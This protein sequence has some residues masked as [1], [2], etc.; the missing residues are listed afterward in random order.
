MQISEFAP[1]YTGR[2]TQPSNPP[3]VSR[4][5]SGASAGGRRD[6]DCTPQN[7][8]P[9]GGLNRDRTG[10]KTVCKGVTVDY[11]GLRVIVKRVRKGVCYG[12]TVA[13][14]EWFARLCKVVKVVG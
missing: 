10:L 12:E 6:G 8:N 7:K 14:H 1:D 9:L 5:P 4:N 2:L 11:Y 3:P 13:T